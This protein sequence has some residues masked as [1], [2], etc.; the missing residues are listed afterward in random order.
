VHV[1]KQ[2]HE[3][4]RPGGVLLDIHPLPGD[5]RVEVMRGQRSTGLGTLDASTD[6]EEIRQA[7]LRLLAVQREGLFSLQ[8]R[9]IFEV[10]IYHEGVDAWLDYRR[11]HGSTTV[12]S[13][14][15]L[16]AARRSTKAKGSVLVIRER[17][18]A[19]VLSANSC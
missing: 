14:E 3:A 13:P 9:R 4:L 1:L 2:I 18:R 17:V 12:I 16:R 15:L 11:E 6:S 19:S 5:L 8:R 10:R 7:R